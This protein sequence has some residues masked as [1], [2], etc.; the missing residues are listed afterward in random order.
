VLYD[1]LGT[2]PFRVFLDIHSTSHA[3]LFPGPMI[4][5]EGDRYRH[6]ILGMRTRQAEPYSGM[7]A[8]AERETGP[9]SGTGVGQTH[10]M[11]LY[12]HGI[13]SIIHE[14]GPNNFYAPPDSIV[15]HY[16]RN[17]RESWF[18]LLEESIHLPAR[19]TGTFA[20]TGSRT[21]APLMPG[22]AVDWMPEV[23]GDP[24]YGVLISLDGAIR[25]T[26]DYKLLPL[27]SR[28]FVLNVSP[29]AKAGT[30]V[31]LRLYLWDRER[32]QSVVDLKVK[33]GG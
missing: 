8:Q 26:G 22:T 30:E 19:R 29:N 23:S 15:A 13:Y 12:A 10:V 1:F 28:G 24:A 11:G 31:P 32:R 16:E 6:L 25:V 18:F 5:E 2:R 4:R 9:T 3:Y 21:T 27:R 20:L 33:I 14:L 17:V 7:P